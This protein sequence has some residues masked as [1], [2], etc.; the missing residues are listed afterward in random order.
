MRSDLDDLIARVE[1]LIRT[2]KRG[3]RAHQKGWACFAKALSSRDP[4]LIDRYVRFSERF[5]R[6]AVLRAAR[7]RG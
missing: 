7:D 2:Y 6:L 5:Y 4:L 1:G 3:R